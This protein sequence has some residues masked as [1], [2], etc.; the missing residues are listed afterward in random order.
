MDLLAHTGGGSGSGTNPVLAPWEIHPI[1]IHFPIAFLLGA[2]VLSAYASRRGRVDLERTATGLLIAGVV[3]GLLAGAAGFLAFFT[4]PDT[5]TELAHRL[6]YWHLGFMAGSLVLYLAVAWLRGRNPDVRPGAGT[7]G[8][9]WL[10]TIV[11][12]VGAAFGGYIVYRGGAGIEAD[13]LKPGLH[14]EHGGPEDHGQA[15][16]HET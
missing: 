14:E 3:T 13:L 15:H 8:V 16:E 2:V 1:L 6:M 9:M 11:F 12:I 10:A 7:Q 4:V 5:H